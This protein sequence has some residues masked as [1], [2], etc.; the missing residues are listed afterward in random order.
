M[1]CP[2]DLLG[3]LQAIRLVQTGARLNRGSFTCCTERSELALTEEENRCAAM[4]LV[5][6]QLSIARWSPSYSSCRASVGIRSEGLRPAALARLSVACLN[7]DDQR[8]NSIRCA[9]RSTPASRAR[10]D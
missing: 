7:P 6:F 3:Y 2:A 8:N 9:E 1:L 4:P 10:P 5:E